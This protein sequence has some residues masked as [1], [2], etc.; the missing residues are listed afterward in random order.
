MM[1]L[2]DAKTIMP[3]SLMLAASTHWL[4]YHALNGLP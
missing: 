1:A 3:S 4:A 2:S